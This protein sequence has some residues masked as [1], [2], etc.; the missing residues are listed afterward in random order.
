MGFS[1]ANEVIVFDEAHNIE[2]V[3]RESASFKIKI[4]ELE[5]AAEDFEKLRKEHQMNSCIYNRLS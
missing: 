1:L 3:C 4:E 2:D 5:F